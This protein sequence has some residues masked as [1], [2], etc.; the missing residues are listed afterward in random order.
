MVAG[1]MEAYLDATA[2]RSPMA[3]GVG[4]LAA[5]LL[6][7]AFAS[8]LGRSFIRLRAAMVFERATMSIMPLEWTAALVDTIGES[9]LEKEASRALVAPICAPA[10]GEDLELG[11]GVMK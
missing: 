11:N 3:F 7:N 5:I 1:D 6:A 8:T 10:W 2:E 4:Y 9:T